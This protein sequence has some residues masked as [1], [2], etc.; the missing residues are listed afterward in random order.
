MVLL[1]L[2]LVK[3]L[4]FSSPVVLV[5]FGEDSCEPQSLLCFHLI[6]SALCFGV[7]FSVL[8]VGKGLG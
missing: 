2:W 4:G 8:A 1:L 3:S 5:E 7:M 6:H